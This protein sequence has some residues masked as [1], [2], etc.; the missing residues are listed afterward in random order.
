MTR[1]RSLCSCIAPLALIALGGVV[2]YLVES[3]ISAEGAAPNGAE[4]AEAPKQPPIS[5]LFPMKRCV[6]RNPRFE[7]LA[8]I[9]K[10]AD[11]EYPDTA[12]R[13]D[14]EPVDWEP[15]ALPVRSARLTLEPG[16]RIIEIGDQ[17]LEVFV[18]RGEVEPPEDW[19]VFRTHPTNSGPWRDCGA[20]HEMTETDGLKRVGEL[21]G[22]ESCF[23]CHD[24][25]RFPEIHAHPEDPLFDCGMCHS[26]H[27]SQRELL[28]RAPVKELCAKCHD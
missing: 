18:A 10:N 23:A 21:K 19:P 13:V 4:V 8:T 6:V 12:L 25:A 1:F 5:L 27:G 17:R 3:D 2:A 24:A 14:G 15:Y 7:L 26:I 9:R 20:C 22:H 11:G 28:L 16:K